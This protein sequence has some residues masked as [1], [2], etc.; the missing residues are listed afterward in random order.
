MQ[1]FH[2]LFIRWRTSSPF[3]FSSYPDQ[4]II[5][6]DWESA[7]GVAILSPL[8]ICQGVVELDYIVYLFL[9]FWGFSTLTSRV[10]EQVCNP[11]T[12]VHLSPHP[13][14]H[15]LLVVLLTFVILIGIKMKLQS[16]FLF[17]FFYLIGSISI[18][19]RYFLA[20]FISF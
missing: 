9:P 7:Y 12:S 13:L 5:E 3:L 20:I 1:Y 6:H 15:L 11:P 8:S 16:C 2:Y 4:S 19:K 18:L 17:A 14:Q 10:V